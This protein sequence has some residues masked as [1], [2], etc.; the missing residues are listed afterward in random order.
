MKKNNFLKKI[1]IAAAIFFVLPLGVVAAGLSNNQENFYLGPDQVLNRNLYRAGNVIIIEGQV[2]G[3]VFLV[4]NSV[5]I[6]GPVAGSVFV[7]GNQVNLT[8]EVAG[9]V[10]AV[11][12]TISV[13]GEVAGSVRTLA[14]N[15]SLNSTVGENLF[16][17]GSV[18]TIGDQASIGWDLFFAGASLE[19]AAPINRH[20][21]LRGA[22]LVLNQRVGG[23]AFVDLKETG[24]MVLL[25][26]AVIEGNLTYL[27]GS[28]NRLDIRE[29][30]TIIGQTNFQS[31]ERAP[32]GWFDFITPQFLFRKVIAIFS[33]IIVGLVLIALAKKQTDRIVD[34]MINRF[35]SAL[36]W[37]VIYFII[38][39]VIAIL[40]LLT[41]IG[42]PLAI[43][44]MILYFLVL[45][46][47]QI[48][49]AIAL[50]ALFIQLINK[51]KEPSLMFSMILGVIIFVF[52]TSLP[53]LG[54]AIKLVAIW[55]GFGACLTIKRLLIKEINS[56]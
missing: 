43:I 1:I 47:S 26:A 3:D 20:A 18:A 54:W 39:P 29:G 25:P 46:F 7:L 40:L 4:G 14:S 10:F 27:A 21:D 56:Y 41:I 23:D 9:S 11:A 36:G 49:A 5:T 45:Y 32:K 6:K 17:A 30:A 33:L 53:F 55:W 50:G 44:L 8:G 24:S 31:V 13:T 52:L 19:I 42:I 22:S 37:G 51:K 28:E 2:N 15:F 35:W 12:S 16:F 48:V 38:T 34:F